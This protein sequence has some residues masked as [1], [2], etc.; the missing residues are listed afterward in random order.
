MTART[1]LHLSW[2]A[3]WWFVVSMCLCGGAAA[4]SMTR[5]FDHLRT[6]FSLG[7]AHAAARC[8]SC[9]V[10]GVFRGTPRDCESCHVSGARFATSG[11]VK[12]AN[13]LPTQQL[14]ASCHNTRSFVGARMSHDGVAKGACAT[15]HNGVQAPGKGANHLRTGASCDTCH[16]TGAWRPA[17][18]GRPA[19][20]G[21]RR[22]ERGRH[23]RGRVCG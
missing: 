13:H 21:G 9:H 19:R 15:C 11:A 4:Q 8:E 18:G 12:T 17:R 1:S 2:L 5:D 16:A 3:L 22:R 7:G 6:G 14:C 23:S 10:G 20:A